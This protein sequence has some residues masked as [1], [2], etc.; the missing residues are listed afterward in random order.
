[1]IPAKENDGPW[2]E[3]RNAHIMHGISRRVINLLACRFG[4]CGGGIAASLMYAFRQVNVIACLI[5]RL[6]NV[7][8]VVW[9]AP[10]DCN[11]LRN[12][13]ANQ[14]AGKAPQAK[15]KMGFREP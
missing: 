8:I 15:K 5:S 7:W 14:I 9:V 2:E 13:R 1:M 11:L 4:A 10:R 12:K 6:S 3:K